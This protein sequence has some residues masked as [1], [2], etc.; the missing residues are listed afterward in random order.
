MVSWIS[1]FLYP[2]I[3]KLPSMVARNGTPR[4]FV[5]P[6]NTLLSRKAKF[7][8]NIRPSVLFCDDELF[9]GPGIQ[10]YNNEV[11]LKNKMSPGIKWFL[12]MQSCPV[13][14][15]CQGFSVAKEYSVGQV[16]TVLPRNTALKGLQH[17]PG[18]QWLPDTKWCRD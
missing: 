7:P 9:C 3:S 2:Q 13:I 1:C 5:L 4:T 8:R 18:I 6:R 14:Q 10:C 16:Y 15:W 12:G 11:F 17:C